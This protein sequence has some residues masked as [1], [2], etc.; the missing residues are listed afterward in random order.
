MSPYATTIITSA[1]NAASCCCA[2]SFFSDDGWHTVR[3][4]RSAIS[5]TGLACSLR[6]LPAGRSGC[7]YTATMRCLL[8]IR[9]ARCE[10]AKPGVPANRMRNEEA[11]TIVR[12]ADAGLFPASYGYAVALGATN[13]RQIIFR[14]DDQL[15]VA[16]KLPP[17]LPVRS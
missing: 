4:A 11:G 3:S 1:L 13:S 5:F 9:C 2:A 16:G 10:A 12:R 8:A 7:V 14:L 15:H 17:G 6:P